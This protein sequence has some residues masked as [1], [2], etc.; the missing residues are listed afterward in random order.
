MPK[1]MPY[2]QQLKG[3]FCQQK[4]NG[5]MPE[6]LKE[7]RRDLGDWKLWKT[8]VVKVNR[9]SMQTT[10]LSTAIDTYPF[11]FLQEFFSEQKNS[12]IS[13]VFIKQQLI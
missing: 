13:I 10:A 6:C 2:T 7:R 4:H 8:E 11:I 1:W 12:R 3:I 5:M 9:Q